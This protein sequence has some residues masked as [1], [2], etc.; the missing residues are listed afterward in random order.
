[1]NEQLRQAPLGVIETTTEGRIVDSNETAAAAIG[2][3]PDALDG[4]DVRE[5]FPKSASGTLR[6]TFEGSPAPRS[7]EEYYPRIERWLAVDV[8]VEETVT[9]YVRD[10]TQRRETEEAVDRLRRRLD[11]VQRI[12]ALVTMVLR[13]VLGASGRAD[14]GETVCDRLGETDLYR[15]VWV[16]ERDFSADRLRVLASAGSAPDVLDR[17]EDALADGATL[18]EER[19]LT[20]GESRLVEAI[21]GDERVPRRVRRAAF[22]RGLQSCLVVPMAYQGTT[23]GVVSVY[24]GQEDGFGEEERAGLETLGRVAGFAIRAIRQ[25]GLLVADTVTEVTVDVRDS[26]VPFVRAAREADCEVSLDGAVPRGDGAVVCYLSPDGTSGAFGE[27]LAG[28]EAVA[29]LRWIRREEDPLVQVTVDGET[30]VTTLAARGGAVGAAEY[31]PRSARLVVEVP[32]DGDVRRTVEAVDATVEETSLAAKAEK[33]RTP[34]SAEAFRD[35]LDERLTDRQ[36]TVLR[37]AYLS[38][39]FESPRGSTSEEVAETLDIAGSTMLYHLRRA[40]QHLAEAF[41]DAADGP[42]PAPDS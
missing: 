39:Y 26:T 34:E 12:H 30:P 23:Y 15:F 16:G 27:A 11:R 40:Q 25:E 31:G 41:Y 35:A 19:A 37:T 14:V 17:V 21:A 1:M 33:R 42:Q 32:P 8:A 5:C 4:A 9:V 29:D 10:R 3:D 36:R 2:A 24:S 7:F 18:P 6:D 13:R 38:D 22:G 28:A 20:D